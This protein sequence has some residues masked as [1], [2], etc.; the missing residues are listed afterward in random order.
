MRSLIYHG[1]VSHVR[2]TPVKHGFRYPIYA[3]CLDLDELPSINSPLFGYNRLRVS[4]FYDTDYLE[5]GPGTLRQKL[6]GHLQSHGLGGVHRIQLITSARYLGYV[7]N[8]VSFYYCWDAA[9]QLVGCLAEVNN[10][11]GE[12]FLYVL[13]EARE[14]LK[15]MLA[16]YTVPK[17]FYVSPFNAI[18]GDYDFHFSDPR[19]RLDIQIHILDRGKVLFRSALT[20]RPRELSPGNH[21]GTL[22]H[23]PV[24][25]AMTVP[26]IMWQ[27]AKLHY[28]K[29]LPPVPKPFPEA[30]TIL[31]AEP[32]G[33]LERS[34]QRLVESYLR[35]I[36]T[37]R[38]TLTLPD[39][40]QKVF[41]GKG[42]RNA[43]LIVNDYDFFRRVAL[44]G[45]VGL[46]ESFQLELWD[47][48][49]VVAFIQLMVDN[50]QAVDDRKFWVSHLSRWVN[51]LK[52]LL[53]KNTLPG[54][55]RNIRQHYDLGNEFFQHFLDESMTY[56]CALFRK[57][58]E[59][60]EEAQEEKLLAVLDKAR[61]SPHHHVLE[62]G[63]GWGSFALLAARR[64]GC[65]VTTLTLSERQFDYVQHRARELGLQDQVQARLC[66]YR[67]AE[68]QYDR[69]VSIEMLEAVGHEHYGQF[70]ATCDRLLKPDGLVV[71]QTITIPDQ[72]YEVYRRSAEW[73]QKHIFPGSNIPSLTT[74]TNAMTKHS[75]FLIESLENIGI[76]YAR[77]LREW[78]R[79]FLSKK[80]LLGKD[81]HFLRTWEYYFSYCEAGFSTRTLGDL[82][83][84]LTR[85]NNPSLP[86]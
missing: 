41:E 68:G 61:V 25:A 55:R 52:H 58:N 80:E 6:A 66:D 39:R 37:G 47:S 71:L 17:E 26:R 28:R 32:P 36:H 79:R 46:G 63:S 11:F 14:P 12:R 75:R 4:S 83:L 18:E 78:R 5:R 65:R 77:T 35:L 30:P 33:W 73:T 72:G 44:D 8:P 21:L 29:G 70:F 42:G 16:R 81:R 50:R 40:T 57:G 10:T 82:Q 20:G 56:S 74:L 67:Q 3:Y 15:G 24:T 85:V 48:P 76:H 31:R 60:L 2:F 45:D 7:F 19:E 9:D 64:T 23:Y 62:I 49:D 69:I 22:L 53:R 43:E 34:C 59:T 84:V 51:R 38:L 27:A 86:S 54:S 1:H 13:K